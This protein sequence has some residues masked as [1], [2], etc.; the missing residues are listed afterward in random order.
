MG[1][2]VHVPAMYW[3]DKDGEYPTKD[4]IMA[5]DQLHN[6]SR[7]N[8]TG[9]FTIHMQ[10]VGGGQEGEQNMMNLKDPQRFNLGKLIIKYFKYGTPKSVQHLD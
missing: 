7:G 1:T 6:S 2:I 4:Y 10:H 8:P 5:G 3:S 9:G